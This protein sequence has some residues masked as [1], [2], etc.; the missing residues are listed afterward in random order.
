MA[1]IS[2][3]IAVC[4]SGLC[5]GDYSVK[6]KLKVDG[7]EFN[8]DIYRVKTHN[9]ITRLE[10]NGRLLLEAV[11]GAAIHNFFI[12]EKRVSFLAEGYN[13]TQITLELEPE[14]EYTVFIDGFNTGKMK[15]N[16]SGKTSFGVELNDKKQEVEIKK[17]V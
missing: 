4:D 16:L 8:G 9:L 12:D 2:E 15:T 14:T 5:F 6:E 13:D 1:V 10:K 11:P 3:G 7:F 17:V